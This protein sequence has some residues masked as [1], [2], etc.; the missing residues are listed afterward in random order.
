M[1]PYFEPVPHDPSCRYCSGAAAVAPLP[2]PVDAVYC[3]SLQEQ[4][5][6]AAAAAA[7][8]HRIGL[9][10]HVTFYRPTRGAYS[11]LAIWNS[12][13][14][15]ACDALKRQCRAALMLEDDVYF[16]QT[17]DPLARRLRRALAALP[18]DWRALFVGY[19]PVQAYFVRRNVLR[20][21]ASCTHAYIA[22]APLLDWL[23]HTEPLGG[24]LATCGWIGATVDGA[25]AELPQMYGLF[26][27]AA[28]QRFLDHAIDPRHDAQGR[29]R[30][31]FDRE[32]WVYY[33]VKYARVFRAAQFAE[34]VAVALS[35]LHRLT[36]ERFRQ[37][38]QAETA[39]TVRLIRASGLFDEAFYLRRQPGVAALR[40]NPLWHYRH[41]GAREGAWPC[42][43]FDPR[44]YAAQNPRLGRGN[45]LV[46]YIR[47]G[48]ALLRKPH[49]LFD[50]AFYVARYGADIPPHM[51]PLAH[52]LSVGGAAG[53]DPHPLFDSAWYLARHPE[54][55]ARAQNPLVHY[56]EEGWR[57]GAAPH[58]QFDGALYLKANP[59]VDAAGVNPLEHFV[60]HGQAEGRPQPI[61]ATAPAAVDI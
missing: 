56:L 6:R 2:A 27:M 3:I 30:P 32:R 35:P 31:V 41:H 55:R 8:F 16:L 17:W 34:A 38:N 11:A 36:L 54:L 19:V 45:P 42:P 58:P 21:R 23:A 13:R 28:V 47:I 57:T 4:P 26:P 50:P 20:V 29:P 10:R 1:Q 37:A 59:D 48:S 39:A 7:H 51:L 52:F 49:P 9:C 44:Y 12:H 24:E 60:R 5:H 33:R 61:P 15:L 43:L 40:I 14:A 25:M 22:G 18:A 53:Y 46:H